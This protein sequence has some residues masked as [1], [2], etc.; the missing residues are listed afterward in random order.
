MCGQMNILIRFEPTISKASMGF[1]GHSLVSSYNLQAL[2]G[3]R[4]HLN[5]LRRH[6]TIGRHSLQY[7]SQR[8]VSG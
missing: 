1:L 8:M 6:L 4:D 3:G 7:V 5:F 2:I